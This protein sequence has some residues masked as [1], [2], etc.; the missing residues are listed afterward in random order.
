MSTD[1]TARLP[2]ASPGV[3]IKLE[4]DVHGGDLVT[5]AD[6]T[7]PL[8]IKEMGETAQVDTSDGLECA[9][10]HVLSKASKT[11]QS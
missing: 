6:I 10:L 2:A 5:D 7:R 4:E 9:H 11:G 8:H 1:E 3:Q